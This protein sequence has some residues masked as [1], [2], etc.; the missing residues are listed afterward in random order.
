[1]S[2]SPS[3]EPTIQ[4]ID[5]SP[6]NVPMRSPYRSAQRTTTVA[7]NVLIIVTLSNG[8]Q[9]F[10]E[11]APAQ[12]VT[13]ETQESVVQSARA[14]AQALMGENTH[15]AFNMLVYAHAKGPGVKGVFEMALLDAQARMLGIP[16]YTLLGAN[17][18]TLPERTTDLSLPLLS[19]DEAAR[20]A[21]EAASV[22]FDVFKIKVGG[23]DT[24][25]DLAR[26]Q[27]VAQAV[28]NALLRL[29]GNQGFAPDKAVQ[30]VQSL[31][32][33]VERVQLFEQP[34]KAGDDE[35]LRHVHQNLPATIPVFADE[36]VHNFRDASR[37]L[38]SGACGGVVLKVA[39][40]GVAGTK[41]IA[42]SVRENG[43]RCMMGC[44]METRIA[45]GAA[46]HLVLALGEKTVPYLDLD[47]TL[48]VRDEELVQG[49]FTLTGNT[50]RADPS[51]PGLGITGVAPALPKT[52]P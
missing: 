19:P 27:A 28:P 46:F 34:T 36:A 50:L 6:W 51:Q 4:R 48:L 31:G 45:I 13:G 47:G 1:M 43:G 41:T 49:G 17:N 32:N 44:M 22:G 39:K 30:F 33:L 42:Q 52:L 3:N 14:L 18:E 12:Y 8:V 20:R 16:L 5:V 37:L 25:E 11:S 2:T 10:G 21:S 26:V 35:A 23:P 40:S 24:G 29:D 9:G 7:Q 38:Q 15:N